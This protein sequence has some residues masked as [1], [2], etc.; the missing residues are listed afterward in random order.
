MD[1]LAPKEYLL[2]PIQNLSGQAAE[3]LG[4]NGQ[5]QS[6]PVIP[7]RSVGATLRLIGTEPAGS[8]LMALGHGP[9]RT[10]QLTEQVPDFS[11]RTVYR[12]LGQLE[13]Y[14]LIEHRAEPGP[15]S[16]VQLRLTEPAGRNLFRVL[17]RFT[18]EAAAGLSSGGAGLTWHSLCLV[19]EM[20]EWGFAVELSHGPRCLVDLLEGTEGLTYHQVRRRATQFV[21]DGLL[22]NCLH[23]GNGRHY[24]LT[25]HGRRCMV[26]IAAIGRWRHRHF[27][28]DGTPGLDLEEMAT[29]LRATLPL[30][31]LPKYAGMNADFIVAGAED[32]YGRRDTV[33]LH[34]AVGQE[35]ALQVSDVGAGEADGSATATLN[36][37]FAA[38]LDGNRGRIRVRGDL[39][40]VDACLTQLYDQLWQPLKR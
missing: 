7:D 37:W 22:D 35:G 31:V 33:S 11:A 17:R 29:V 10:K 39:A 13:A 28:A 8:M 32:K 1:S 30:V 9:L 40:L 38:L 24:E 23:D 16:R 25:D 20:W 14:G 36:T 19:G 6:N 15:R 18:S 2:V 4:L 21:D 12:C 34:G 5:S 3:A 26:V 27:L